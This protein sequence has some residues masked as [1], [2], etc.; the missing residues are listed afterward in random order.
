MAFPAAAYKAP[1]VETLWVRMA[2]LMASRTSL[3]WSSAWTLVVRSARCGAP[4]W[5]G[6]VMGRGSRRLSVHVCCLVA[7]ALA[8]LCCCCCCCCCCCHSCFVLP[9]HP[10]LSILCLGAWLWCH[11]RGRGQENFCQFF[12]WQLKWCRCVVKVHILKWLVLMSTAG[13]RWSAGVEVVHLHAPSLLHAAYCLMASHTGLPP[14]HPDS[15]WQPEH[16][17]NVAEKDLPRFC[18]W[19]MAIPQA[20]GGCANFKRLTM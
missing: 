8:S 7:A 5:H 14:A 17:P 6:W 15:C 2:A 12:P 1:L 11:S 18:Y 4:C 16:G 20:P 9:T 3:R 19:A 13:W 10:P